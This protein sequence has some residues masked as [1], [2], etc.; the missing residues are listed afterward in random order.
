LKVIYCAGGKLPQQVCDELCEIAVQ[1]CGVRIPL[2]T[3]LGCPEAAPHALFG[4]KESDQSCLVGV[5]APG[6]E[7][8]L[9]P[10]GDGSF[11]ARLRGPNVTFAIGADWT[12]HGQH[13]M[14]KGSS[15]WGTAS[16]LRMIT[17]LEKVSSLTV[18]K[19]R[20]RR[21]VHHFFWK[22]NG[23]RPVWP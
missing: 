4:L 9:V 21:V 1:E 23:E 14:K 2:L 7:L 12:S 15:K 11:E 22:K 3:G 13:S 16:D 8:K 17:I 6:M 20:A 19:I 5:P 18:R 10:K